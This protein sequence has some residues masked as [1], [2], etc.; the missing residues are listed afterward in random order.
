MD[1]D[2]DSVV[3]LTAVDAV[4]YGA[5]SGAWGAGANWSGGVEP[6]AGDTVYIP[7]EAGGNTT[8]TGPVGDV[9]VDSLTVG[10]PGESPTSTTRTTL[11][12]GAGVLTTTR[13]TTVRTDGVLAGDGTLAG[14]IYNAGHVQPGRVG[15]LLVI[16]GPYRQNENGT[17]D[18]E[19]LGTSP[20]DHSLLHVAGPLQLD[21]VLEVRAAAGFT[22]QS[23]DLYAILAY[24]TRTGDFA[25][26]ENSTGLDDLI[27]DI[28][29][30]DEAGTGTL[31]VT[32]FEDEVDRAV[33]L[34]T[35]F[36]AVV[37]DLDSDRAP[38]TRWTRS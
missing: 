33:V 30:D 37:L 31:T 14:A 1:G 19:L 11:L 4:T 34:D 2:G 17:L 28:I 21:G 8:V 29:Y 9:G 12:L 26:I 10:A 22:P 5:M 36:G 35:S 13:G 18:V 23:G 27:F 32:G 3:R 7:G 20:G 15:G 25:R 16:D 38:V 24:G 6:R